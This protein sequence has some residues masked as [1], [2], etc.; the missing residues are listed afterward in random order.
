MTDAGSSAEKQ[1]DTLGVTRQRLP[2]SSD[3]VYDYD[4]SPRALP[5]PVTRLSASLTRAAAAAAVS[6]ARPSLNF[7]AVF[8]EA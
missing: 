4:R 5:D 1:S 8:C 3:H 2:H 6:P 7:T